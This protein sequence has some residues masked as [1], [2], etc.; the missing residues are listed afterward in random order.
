M[1]WIILIKLL[2]MVLLFLLILIVGSLPIRVSAFK[3]N[4]MLLALTR[5]FSGGL[6]LA[7]GIVHLLPE[8]AENFEDYFKSNGYQGEQFPWAFLILLISFSLVLF[9]EKIATDHHHSH[10]E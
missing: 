8:A 6:F 9:I 2:S 3:N 10:P 4:N 5:A 7:V 1:D